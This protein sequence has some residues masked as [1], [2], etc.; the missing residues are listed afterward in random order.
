MEIRMSG[1][2]TFILLTAQPGF[3][4]IYPGKGDFFTYKKCHTNLL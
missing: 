1:I 2:Y 4:L 3:E